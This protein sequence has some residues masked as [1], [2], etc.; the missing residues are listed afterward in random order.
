MNY[1]SFNWQWLTR[2]A[3]ARL[4]GAAVL[5]MAAGSMSFADDPALRVARVSLTEGQVSYQRAADNDNGWTG[6]TVNT[7]L[8][9]NDQVQ[10]G[11][12]GRAAIQLTGRNLVRLDYDTSF[13]ITQFNTGTTQLALPA[14]TAT[15]RI[16]S[17]D[18]RQF[19]LT[20]AQEAGDWGNV[21]FEIDTPAAAVT[22]LKDGVY[23]INARQDG[24]TEVETW[25]GEAEVYNQ[26]L[27]VV[28]V[29]QGSEMIVGAGADSYRM[30]RAADKD[31]WDRW[32]DGLDSER[33]YTATSSVSAHYVPAGLPGVYDLDV[34]GDWWYAQD[35]GYVWS[36]R[37]IATG[38]APYR[39]GAWRWDPFFGWTWISSEPWGWA[40]YHYGR[41]AFYSGRWCWV[42]RGGFSAGVAWSWSPALV[43]FVGF[44]SP[45]V[46]VVGRDW[47][48]WVPL[49]PGER[50][51]RQTTII[52]NTTINRTT[53]NRTV[54]ELRNYSAPGGLTGMSGRS[55][56]DRRVVVNNIIAPPRDVNLN[57]NVRLM[58]PRSEDF[59][60]QRAVATRIS[61]GATMP[62]SRFASRPVI[63]RNAGVTPSMPNQAL[64]A[65]GKAMPKPPVEMRNEGPVNR[66]E[67]QRIE[68]LAPPRQIER[69]NGAGIERHET[70]PTMVRPPR[71]PEVNR[72]V[73]LAPPRVEPPAGFR[74]ERPAPMPP[75]RRPTG[76]IRPPRELRLFRR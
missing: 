76:A 31:E 12:D 13:R 25:R 52:N 8:N 65:R 6:A 36:P 4:A 28:S 67:Q 40:P 66:P 38:W 51:V 20:S 69:G 41:W 59:R 48:G 55:F 53:I 57:T 73:E 2:R 50:F 70:P 11:A 47:I 32:N 19:Q 42:P 5:L 61:T 46:H 17:L 49:A 1:F 22:L 14:G 62:V 63:T 54:T 74:M 68:P 27:G 43:T 72:H 45:G 21:Y 64:P 35:Y 44:G 16:D 75:Q 7:P 34:Y 15:F 29:K 30:A 33:L 58:A 23:R 24:T 9:V 26:K 39:V 3:V 56:A 71:L 37:V 60:P 10:T 18:P